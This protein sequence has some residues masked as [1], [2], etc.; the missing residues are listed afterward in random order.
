MDVPSNIAA[1]SSLAA[2]SFRRQETAAPLI[3]AGGVA[4]IAPLLFVFYGCLTALLWRLSK[5][6][7]F[8]WALMI[9]GAVAI[10]VTTAMGV[11]HTH[12]S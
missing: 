2:H 4:G 6:M 5:A 9:A 11:M 3:P 8:E 1:S 10:V 7:P 12:L